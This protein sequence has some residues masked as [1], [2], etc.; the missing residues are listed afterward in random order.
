VGFPLELFNLI[1]RLLLAF[2]GKGRIL[3][4]LDLSLKACKGDVSRFILDGLLLGVR[5]RYQED[6]PLWGARIITLL[7]N[8]FIKFYLFFKKYRKKN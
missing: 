6:T 4:L 5:S 8:N 2:L 7:G 1:L 3:G